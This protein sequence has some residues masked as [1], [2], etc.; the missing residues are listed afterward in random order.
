MDDFEKMVPLIHSM[1]PNAPEKTICAFVPNDEEKEKALKAG[2][3]YAGGE[4][5]LQEI[6]KGRIELV[7]N[8]PD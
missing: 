6:I 4:E 2:A 3:I 8:S 5:L 7:G 1:D